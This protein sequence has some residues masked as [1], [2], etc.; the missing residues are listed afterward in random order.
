[1]YKLNYLHKHRRTVLSAPCWRYV[2][3]NRWPWSCEQQ[4]CPSEGTGCRSGSRRPRPAIG[5]ILT[6]KWNNGVLTRTALLDL[7]FWILNGQCLVIND[8]DIQTRYIDNANTSIGL[9]HT[10]NLYITLSVPCWKVTIAAQFSWKANVRKS[11]TVPGSG[12]C[13]S[14]YRRAHVKLWKRL[15][16]I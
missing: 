2:C 10:H 5:F 11:S 7:M 16:Q 4:T 6:V 1:L 9:H 14:R 15:W 13:V 12:V 8:Q 3:L